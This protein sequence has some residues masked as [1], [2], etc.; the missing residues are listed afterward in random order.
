MKR[1]DFNSPDFKGFEN[2]EKILLDTGIILALANE[3]DAWHNTVTDLFSNH[4]LTDDNDENNKA[5]FLFIN[6][7]ILNEITHLADRPFK[8]YAIKNK[9]I[10]LST[11]DPQ[12]VVGDTVSNVK[13]LIENEVLLIADGNKESAIKQIELYSILGSADAANIS[14]ANEL[15]LNFL[16]V[17][18]RLS[19]NIYRIK[20]KLRKISKVYYTKNHYRTY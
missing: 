16:T 13:T 17:D 8:Q 20:N 4:I 1:I 10:D 7:T 14:I 9:Q 2:N 3:Y 15:G 19:S 18:I 11:I 6:P 5:L 12:A